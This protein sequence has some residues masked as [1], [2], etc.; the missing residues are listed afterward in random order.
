MGLFCLL[1]WTILYEKILQFGID[2]TGQIECAKDNYFRFL[3]LATA[4]C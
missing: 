3:L 4:I 2:L 1:Y